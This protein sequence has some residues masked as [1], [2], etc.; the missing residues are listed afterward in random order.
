V[1]LPELLLA[2]AVTAYGKGLYR[3]QQTMMRLEAEGYLVMR[4]PGSHGQPDVVAVKPGQVLAI[5]VKSGVARL[6]HGW[7]N[8]LYSTALRAGAIPIVADWPKR[9]CLRMRRITGLHRAHSQR[10]P[11]EDFTTDLVVPEE[12]MEP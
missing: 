9:G 11:L 6:D 4:A 1:G 5:Q 8:E 3:E 7:F 12:W 10:W 2:R